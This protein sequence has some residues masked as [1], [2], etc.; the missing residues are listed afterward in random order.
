MLTIKPF[1][2]QNWAPPLQI[3]CLCHLTCMEACGQR[4]VGCLRP[5]RGREPSLWPIASRTP[6]EAALAP[7]SPQQR[8]SVDKFSLTVLYEWTVQQRSE[9]VFV[10]LI[11]QEENRNNLSLSIIIYIYTLPTLPTIKIIFRNT[12]MAYSFCPQLSCRAALLWSCPW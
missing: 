8:R 9:W 3:T 5:M 11:I 4:W 12:S 1:I 2:L 10:I 6:S 7:A